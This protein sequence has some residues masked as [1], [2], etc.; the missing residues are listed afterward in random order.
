LSQVARLLEQIQANPRAVRFRDLER[1]LVHHGVSVRE[2]KGSHRVA[3]REGELY[4]IKDP[5]SRGFV[6]PKTVKH[7]LRAFGLWR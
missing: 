5:G 7:C 1:V 4:T 2:G 6:H 3:E